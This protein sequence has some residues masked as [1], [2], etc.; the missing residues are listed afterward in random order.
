MTWVVQGFPTLEFKTEGEALAAAWAT[1]PAG[2][3]RPEVTQRT[4]DAPADVEYLK[5]KRWTLEPVDLTRDSEHWRKEMT[6]EL[7][8]KAKGL[9]V[10]LDSDTFEMEAT[11]ASVRA[12]CRIKGRVPTGGEAAAD[13]EKYRHLFLGDAE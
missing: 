2:G 4:S 8:I 1:T 3:K 9:G 11:T 7:N 10:I 5:A 13:A 12:R 6:R